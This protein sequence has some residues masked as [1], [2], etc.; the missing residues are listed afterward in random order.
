MHISSENREALQELLNIGVE[1]AAGSLNQMLEKP[2]RLHIP[3]I[4]L[5]RVDD[6]FHEASKVNEGTLAT[7]QLDFTGTFSGS[8]CLLVPL[9]HA[10]TLATALTG[11][12]EDVGTISSLQEVALNEIGN[13]VLNGVM[14]TMANIMQHPITYSV[15]VYQETSLPRL[16]QIPL[17][18]PYE[19]A[20]SSQTR[21]TIDDCDL[22]GDIILLMGIPDS[23]LLM[24][25]LRGLTLATSLHDNSSG[26]AT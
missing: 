9:E 21:F 14:G 4:Q 3:F 10:T 16:F 7:V 25:T 18:P 12:T 13:I 15:P 19:M 23:E 8:A 5:A 22:R 11:E 24:N 17:T 2:I 6:I 1:R 26:P 20:L